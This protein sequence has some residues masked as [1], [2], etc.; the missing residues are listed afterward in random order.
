M[1][2]PAAGIVL[3]GGRSRRM[4]RAK[5]TLPFGRETMLQRVVGRLGEAVDSI[6]VVTAAEQQLP[7][8]PSSII[9]A[10]DRRPDRGPLE[11]LAAGLRALGDR[12]ELAY[13]SAC[14]V[15]LLAPAFVCRMLELSAGHDVAVPHVD[16]FEHPL[17]AVYRVDVLPQVEALLE[18][19]R[20]RPAFLFDRVRTRRVAAEELTDADPKLETLAN[21]NSP[22]DYAAVLKLAGLPGVPPK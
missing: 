5:A 14:D 13:V 3:C 7:E 8:L 15:P 6:V 9:L 22:E 10:R 18:A 4:G 1:S 16:G 2:L 21:V 12:A 19:D 11:G 17:A 20:L